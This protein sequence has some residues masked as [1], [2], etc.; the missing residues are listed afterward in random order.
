[1]LSSCPVT[2]R[3]R[4]DCTRP[5]GLP[6][7]APPAGRCGGASS[8][9]YSWLRCSERQSA[10]PPVGASGSLVD[11]GINDQF[12]KELGQKL[13]PGGAAVIVLVHEVTPDK[14]LP[15]IEQYGGEVIQTSLGEESETR[16]R[17]ALEA[18]EHAGPAA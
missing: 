3:G 2:R 13:T 1:M 14:V 4:S 10:R 9:S 7:P 15:L 12:L 16:L 17:E 11:F 5:S 6:R 8:A 18:P